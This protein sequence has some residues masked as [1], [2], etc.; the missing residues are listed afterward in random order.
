[1]S[2]LKHL[3]V[4]SRDEIE[5]QCIYIWK[6]CLCNWLPGE[7]LIDNWMRKIEREKERTFQLIGWYSFNF[8][9]LTDF[10]DS[11]CLSLSLFQMTQFYLIISLSLK[12]YKILDGRWVTQ[13]INVFCCLYFLW[14]TFVCRFHTELNQLLLLEEK[15]KI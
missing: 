1:M 2:D 4:C 13:L 12:L 5:F 7:V 9:H 14:V 8:Y 10:T 3:K 6:S 11:A 15:N